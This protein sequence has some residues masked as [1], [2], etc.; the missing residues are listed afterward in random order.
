MDVTEDQGTCQL[1]GCDAPAVC[2]LMVKGV[3]WRSCRR[4]LAAVGGRLIESLRQAA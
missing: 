4:H 2:V 1:D 3:M